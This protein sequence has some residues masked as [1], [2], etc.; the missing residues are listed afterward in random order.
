MSRKVLK[1][2][3]KYPVHLYYL[4]IKITYYSHHFS[5]KGCQMIKKQFALFLF[6]IAFLSGCGKRKDKNM[7]MAKG[8]SFSQV[9]IPLAGDQVATADDSVRSFFDS[10]IKEFV[11]MDGENSSEAGSVNDFAWV[12]ANEKDSTFKTVYFDFDKHTVRTDQ[13]ES[14]KYDVGQAR[15]TIEDATKANQK[16]AVVIEGHSC[17]SAGSSA[18]NLALSEKRAKA[19][20]NQLTVSGFPKDTIKVVGRGQ[21]VPVVNGTREQQWKN[22]R[23]EFHV[24]QS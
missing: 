5:K 19:V 23:V 12:D 10:D 18:Y 13:Q 14:V 22:R 21:D 8:D 3:L 4:K 17:H 2:V 11:A 15:K 16:V 1:N 6:G 24:V 9:D 20:A 7:R